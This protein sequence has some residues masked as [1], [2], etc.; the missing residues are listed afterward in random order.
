MPEIDNFCYEECPSPDELADGEVSVQTLYLSLD[1][2]LVYDTQCKKRA[3]IIAIYGQCRPRS[4]C[5][6]G[7]ADQGHHCPFTE[8][9]DTVVCVDE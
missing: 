7:Q 9:V 5:P 6:F 2:A 1:P 8:S 4:A 3:F